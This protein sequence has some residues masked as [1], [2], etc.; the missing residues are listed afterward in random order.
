MKFATVFTVLAA[1]LLVARAQPVDEILNDEETAVVFS[2]S[3]IEAE[4]DS[5]DEKLEY[6]SDYV[7]NIKDN[8]SNE[9]TVGVASL[10]D[11]DLNMD[12][13]HFDGAFQDADFTNY[14]DFTNVTQSNIYDLY[15]KYQKREKYQKQSG[16]DLNGYVDSL[17]E[18][19]TSFIP[20]WNKESFKGKWNYIDGVFLNSV[21]NLYKKTKNEKYKDFFLKYVNYYIA[22]DGTFVHYTADGVKT[23]DNALGWVDG[24]L[25]TICESKILFDAYEMTGDERYL[26]AIEFSYKKLMEM[27]ICEGSP[28]FWHKTFYIHQIWLDGMYMYAPFLARYAVLKNDLSILD[29]IKEQY[30]FIHDNMRDENG[31]YHHGF[32]TTKKIFWSLN[33]DGKS[34]NFWLRSMGWFSVSLVDILE[35]YPEGADK[36]YLK[37][38][39]EELLNGILPYQDKITKMFYQVIDRPEEIQLVDKF[40]FN[41]L[42]NKKYGNID[43]FVANYVESSGSSMMAYSFLKFGKVYHNEKFEKIGREIFEAIYQHSYQNNT[44]SDICITAGLG[45]ENKPYRDGTL[46][47]YL[48]EKVGEDDAKGVGPFLMAFIEYEYNN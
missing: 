38:I 45:P 41:S 7:F 28:N 13:Y 40:Y 26:T 12:G 32:D 30:A 31:L 27:P 18:R 2:D 1:T 33:N 29:T 8:L 15:L 6:V 16:I 23:I 34:E 14:F 37:S 22:E 46:S 36:E 3:E 24:E 44:L 48:A 20:Y 21:V 10:E 19:T 43:T 11:L 9:K 17:I 5:A 39:L 42:G 25:D 47:Y 4:V 35:Y